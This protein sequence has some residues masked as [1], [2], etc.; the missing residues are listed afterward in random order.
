[1]QQLKACVLN[2]SQDLTPAAQAFSSRLAVCFVNQGSTRPCL[3]QHHRLRVSRVS[4]DLIRLARACHR[5]WV[6]LYAYLGDTPRFLL[7]LR[8]TNAAFALQDPS[9]R[10]LEYPI[11]Q[12]VH[13]VDWGHIQH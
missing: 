9:R 10:F 5:L 2:V 11:R 7:R 12:A 3:A 1:M 8:Q 4:L 6:A 13:Y